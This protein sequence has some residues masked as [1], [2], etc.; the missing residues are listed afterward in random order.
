MFDVVR[1]RESPCLLHNFV[2]LE[3]TLM[4][5]FIMIEWRIEALCVLLV[6]KT[7]I[8]TKTFGCKQAALSGRKKL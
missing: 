2:Q 1:K 5:F 8:T 6:D 4:P 3:A 7:N